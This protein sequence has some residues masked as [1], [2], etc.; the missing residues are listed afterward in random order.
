MRRHRPWMQSVG[1]HLFCK[2]DLWKESV[3]HCK[4]RRILNIICMNKCLKS[5]LLASDWYSLVPRPYGVDPALLER[6]STIQ[7]IVLAASIMHR[8]LSGQKGDGVG[9]VINMKHMSCIDRAQP[10][11][12]PSSAEGLQSETTDKCPLSRPSSVGPP[13]R[14]NQAKVEI[15]PDDLPSCQAVHSF[16]LLV[17]FFYFIL[18][19][20]QGDWWNS[21]FS[22]MTLT[23]A[24]S[25]KMHGF[26]GQVPPMRLLLMR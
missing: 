3:F 7:Y 21:C 1:G 25:N 26:S 20:G 5:G 2:G 11:W 9:R 24:R 16:A 4:Y 18:Y 17:V 19:F 8:R 13:E 14:T 22:I 12:H 15:C 10:S 6:Q 23:D